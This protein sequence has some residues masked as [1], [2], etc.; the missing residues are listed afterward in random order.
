MA[1]QPGSAPPW[2]AFDA[3]SSPPPRQRG[4]APKEHKVSDRSQPPASGDVNRDPAVPSPLPGEPGIPDVAQPSRP[5]GSRKALV[6][7]A[8]F[9]L[10]LIAVSA[11]SIQRFMGS[12]KPDDIESKRNSDRPAAASTDPK[13]LDL[14]VAAAPAPSQPASA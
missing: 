1:S 14:T 8:I 12:K 4:A 10:S 13:R 5:R 9:V 11:I 3:S 7:L 6:A 2:R